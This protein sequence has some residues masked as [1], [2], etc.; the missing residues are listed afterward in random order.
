M[1]KPKYSITA[2]II[3]LTEMGDPYKGTLA[4]NYC[5]LTGLM[6]SKQTYKISH[7]TEVLEFYKSFY[8]NRNLKFKLLFKMSDDKILDQLLDIKKR[9]NGK[10]NNIKTI[11]DALS[12][13]LLDWGKSWVNTR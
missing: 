12:I 1:S 9:Y 5:I 2:N 7:I 11:E 13:L 6:F 8:N 3:Y 10:Y 4:S